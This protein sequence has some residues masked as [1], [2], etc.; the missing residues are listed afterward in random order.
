M[1]MPGALEALRV[2]ELAMLV[3]IVF[4]RV[5]HITKYVDASIGGKD[6]SIKPMGESAG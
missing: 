1:S 4:G 3:F 2:F 6:L 5:P